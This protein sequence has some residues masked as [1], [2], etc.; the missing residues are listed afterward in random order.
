MQLILYVTAKL[1]A[2]ENSYLQLTGY[3]KCK[4][5]CPLENVDWLPLAPYPTYSWQKVAYSL[6]LVVWMVAIRTGHIYRHLMGFFLLGEVF[7]AW[8]ETG[9][10]EFNGRSIKALS[11]ASR[12]GSPEVYKT[13]V[14]STVHMTMYTML[15]Y[16]W[17]F[18]I[19]GFF[20]SLSIL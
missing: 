3:R 8:G 15:Q 1:F 14:Y 16:F 11:S 17:F 7:L 4:D 19:C 13:V 20:P 18:H 10:G 5:K 2:F 6:F 12:R 9:W